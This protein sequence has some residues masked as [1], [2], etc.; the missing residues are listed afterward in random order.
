MWMGSMWMKMAAAV[1][2]PTVFA[3]P[4]AQALLSGAG[5]RSAVATL[6][7]HW[8]GAPGG[9]AREAPRAPV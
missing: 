8:Y 2:R 1:R 3:Q 7:G 6:V 4:P 9:G 5:S